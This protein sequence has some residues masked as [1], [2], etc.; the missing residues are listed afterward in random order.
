MVILAILETLDTN[1]LSPPVIIKV[2]LLQLRLQD[3]HKLIEL[4]LMAEP[5]EVK[6]PLCMTKPE[7]LLKMYMKVIWLVKL[8]EK[9]D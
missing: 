8:L 4:A 2:P 1:K 3:Y 5:K 6:V 9:R 7:L